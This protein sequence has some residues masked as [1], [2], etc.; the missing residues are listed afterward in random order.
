MSASFSETYTPEKKRTMTNDT[1]LE[2]KNVSIRF[3]GLRALDGVSFSVKKGSITG[4][5]GPNGAGKTTL[6]N[7]ISGVYVPTDGE[8]HF[9]GGPLPLGKPEEVA[10]TGV[11]RTF[12]NLRLFKD[13]SA[14]DNV[15]TAIDQSRLEKKQSALWAVLG[16]PSFLNLE[17]QKHEK[18]MHFLREVGLD[19]RATEITKNLPYGEQK[20]LEI[21]RALALSPKLILL[22]EPAAGLNAKETRELLDLLNLFKDRYQLTFVLIE[23][24]MKLVMGLCDQIV[25][26]NF[27]K[28]IA[29]GTPKEIQTNHAVRAAYLGKK[30]ENHASPNP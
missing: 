25:V 16:A 23:H 19:H 1:L 6:F 13:L 22:D 30:G 18:A 11:A 29:E 14:L 7:L 15:L 10:R 26:L 27:G 17:A 12:Q 8:I 21:A 5:I 28:Q 2:L 24:D 9:E 4:V 20:R 3:G